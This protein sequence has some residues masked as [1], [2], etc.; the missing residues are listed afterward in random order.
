MR[1]AFRR[2]RRVDLPACLPLISDRAL[3]DEDA[4]RHL[5]SMWNEIIARG[6]GESAVVFERGPAERIVAFGMSVFI[7]RSYA[8]Q[9]A[10]RPEPFIARE[11]LRCWRAGRAPFLDESG[12]AR[13]TAS[14]GVDLLVLHQGFAEPWDA[15]AMGEVRL[16]LAQAFLGTHA[17][18]RFRSFTHEMYPNAAEGD[19]ATFGSPSHRAA[20]AGGFIIRA[21]FEPN[22]SRPEP[23]TFVIGITRDEA[24]Q[25]PGH[26]AP[27]VMF[28]WDDR[29][30][31]GLDAA[32]RRI[33]KLALD[34]A[35]D[36]TIA[37]DLYLSVGAVK[38]RWRAMFERIETIDPN[39]FRSADGSGGRR[40]AELRR[41]VVRFVRNH[42]EELYPYEATRTPSELYDTQRK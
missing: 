10:A 15:G 1:F 32:S 36:E 37:E 20:I 30:R 26:Y 41:H 19:A 13:A 11:M 17:G 8:D 12:V 16:E 33:L 24:R 27:D 38:K 3:Y 5:A 39:V 28:G 34:G 23:A 9:L 42:P 21:A 31:Y 29:P 40:G 14:D 7:E 4:L 6:I 22:L 2:T 18:L 25:Q 35:T